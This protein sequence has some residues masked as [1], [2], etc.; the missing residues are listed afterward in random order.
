MWIDPI[1][2]EIHIIRE[3]HARRFK[4]DMDAIFSDWLE[5]Q[6]HSGRTYVSFPQQNRRVAEPSNGYSKSQMQKDE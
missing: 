5:K 2:D 4:F 1:I 3:M 6:R